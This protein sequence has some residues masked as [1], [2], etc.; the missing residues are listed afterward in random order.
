MRRLEG[1]SQL[2]EVA[3]SFPED[4]RLQWYANA[5]IV[6]RPYADRLRS[7]TR[8]LDASNAPA[9]AGPSR[10]PLWFRE[11]RWFR[12]PPKSGEYIRHILM[13]IHRLV[14]GGPH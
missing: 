10:M 8:F 14:R 13:R 6:K 1:W 3:R 2:A 4:A 5:S 9:A 7:F 12:S 11:L